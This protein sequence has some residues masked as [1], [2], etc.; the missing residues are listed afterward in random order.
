M[1]TE[2]FKEPCKKEVQKIEKLNIISLEKS[3][4]EIEQMLK[5]AN[6]GRKN[7]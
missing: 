3:K 6:N 7:K 2:V 1:R 4:K 5:E